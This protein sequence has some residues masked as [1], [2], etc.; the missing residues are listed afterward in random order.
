MEFVVVY[1]G[2]SFIFM[3]HALLGVVGVGGGKNTNGHFFLQ[4]LCDCVATVHGF[5]LLGVPDV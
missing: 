3:G 5:S 4:A 1:L 2:I